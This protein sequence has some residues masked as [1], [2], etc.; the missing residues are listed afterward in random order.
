MFHIDLDNYGS[1]AHLSSPIPCVHIYRNTPASVIKKFFD[2]FDLELQVAGVPKRRTI[3]DS[4]AAMLSPDGET[5]PDDVF[6]LYAVDWKT[7]RTVLWVLLSGLSE[8]YRK[9]KEKA[10]GITEEGSK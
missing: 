4:Y 6:F 10:G 8:E 9:A 3:N 1:D 7:G 5:F 2:L